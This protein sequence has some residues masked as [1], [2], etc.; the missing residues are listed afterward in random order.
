MPP[1]CVAGISQSLNC[2]ALDS[3]AQAA[4]HQRVIELLLLGKSGGVDGFEAAQRLARV[5][6]IVGDRLV[7]KIAEPIV[8]AVVA[9]LGGEFGLSAQRVFPLVGEQAI[10]FGATRLQTLF[11]AQSRAAEETRA[12]DPSTSKKFATCRP[13]VSVG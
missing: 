12:S 4:H 13:P 11:G 9:D 5:L 1:N 7:G 6:E 10:E 3:V 8:V 2:G